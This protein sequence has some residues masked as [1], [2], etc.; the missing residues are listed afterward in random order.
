MINTL[1]DQGIGNIAEN[2]IQLFTTT[3]V[4]LAGTPMDDSTF[5]KGVGWLDPIPNPWNPTAPLYPKY[6]NIFDF[7]NYLTGFTADQYDGS[8]RNIGPSAY[9]PTGNTL[10]YS[11]YNDMIIGYSGDPD[12][13]DAVPNDGAM[14]SWEDY[15]VL[16]IDEAREDLIVWLSGTAGTF[17]K[18]YWDLLPTGSTP[19]QHRQ[20]VIQ[21]PLLSLQAASSPSKPRSW[22]NR[23]CLV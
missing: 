4:H 23:P 13:Y 17:I 22:R 9:D 19:I 8:Q 1:G 21:L 12:R 14:Q 20:E 7:V 10:Q 6:D 2:D 16:T 5:S 11:T 3:G 18:P 15:E